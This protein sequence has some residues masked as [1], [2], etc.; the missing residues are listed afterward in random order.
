MLFVLAGCAGQELSR[1]NPVPV[2]AEYVTGL[3]ANATWRALMRFASRNGYHFVKLE[4]EKGI[5]EISAGDIFDGDYSSYYLHYNLVVVGLA[6]GTK[7]VVDTG[8]FDNNGREVEFQRHMEK[9]KE[10]K[11]RQI[12]Q[13]IKKFLENGQK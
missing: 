11:D 9:M 8:F 13:E 2:P 5:M 4:S 6:Q 12:L 10:N 3:D 1:E 7:V